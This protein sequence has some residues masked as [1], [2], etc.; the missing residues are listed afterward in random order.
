MQTKLED[1]FFHVKIQDKTTLKVNLEDFENDKSVKGEFVRAVL[2][3]NLTEE[4][5]NKVLACGFNALAG[6]EL[7]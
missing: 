4:D 6:E 3:S 7:L 1:W 2:Q 5:K